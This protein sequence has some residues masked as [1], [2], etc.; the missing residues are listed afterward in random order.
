M[1][2]FDFAAVYDALRAKAAQLR[3]QLEARIKDNLSG[4]VLR[5]RSGTLMD[6]IGSEIDD[7]GTAIRISAGSSGVAY[8]AIQEY[9]GK[10]GAHEIVAKG[11]AL[12]VASLD[13][14]V[15]AAH[16]HHPGS[17]IPARSYL[18]SALE[19]MAEEIEAALQQAALDILQD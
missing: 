12:A 10:T 1:S 6:S 15:F 19:A 13:G 3:D 2:T 16:V 4:T 7:D 18:G 8:A 11:K 17:N 9:G 14:E 5:Q